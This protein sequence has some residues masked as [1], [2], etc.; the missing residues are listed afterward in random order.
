MKDKDK[1]LGHVLA[2]PVSSALLIAVY[3]GRNNPDDLKSYLEGDEVM[4]NYHMKYL[5]ERKLVNIDNSGVYSITKDGKTIAED[6]IKA[7]KA[8]E[9]IELPVNLA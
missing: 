9:E 5:L 6:T 3:K 8:A 1:I 7:V 2:S 4:L